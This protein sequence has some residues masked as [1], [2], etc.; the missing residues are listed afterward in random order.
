CLRSEAQ[1]AAACYG[2][3]Y[4]IVQ[5]LTMAATI[6]ALF[7][8]FSMSRRFAALAFVL[9]LPFC[10]IAANWP[11]WRGPAGDATSPET[12]LPLRWSQPENIR[13]KC[14]LPDAAS[15][16]VVWG[17]AVFGTGHDGDKLLAY[18]ID[19]ADGSIVWTRQ[20]GTANPIRT[21]PSGTKYDRGSQ[22]YNR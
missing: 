18:R 14:P 20:V 13:W 4:V 12:D 15:T 11:Q 19:A 8:R 21:P 7:G 5:P 1:P 3:L 6:A 17:D 10:A 16:P 22:K 2:R 9:L